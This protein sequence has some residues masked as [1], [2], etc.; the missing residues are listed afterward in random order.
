MS[1]PFRW[2]LLLSAVCLFWGTIPLVAAEIA[3]P[4]PAIAAGRIWLAA[5]GLGVLVATTRRR[6]P[7]LLAYRPGRS[8]AVG[9]ILAVHWSAMF[10]AYERAPDDTVIFVIFLAPV[11]IAALAPR[12]LGEAVT[13]KTVVALVLALCGFGLVAG[14]TVDGAAAAGI[15]WAV[16]S[17]AT[18]VAL[19]LL[20]KPL[21]ETYGGL[22]LTFL[23]MAAAGVVL[24]PVVASADWSGLGGSWRWLLLLGLVHTAIGTAVYL[25]ALARIPATHVGILGYLEPVGVVLFAWLVT[26]D[27][28]R[29]TTVLG[30]ALIVGAGVLV[31]RSA[32]QTAVEVTGVPG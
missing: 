9:G 26:A 10:A 23:E 4:A 16:L 8:I 17:A 7:R 25:A 21:A 19:V 20:A 22:R 2:Y 6:E 28:P 18:F 3:L 1:G 31:I 24:L 11:G 13:A 29:A 15:G 32:R 5:V 14:P 30:G 27:A 12:T